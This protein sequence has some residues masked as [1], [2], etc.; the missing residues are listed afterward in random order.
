MPLDSKTNHAHKLIDHLVYMI[1]IK[2]AQGGHIDILTE[3]NSFK[4]REQ[5]SLCTLDTW[6]LG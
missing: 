3:H 2:I 4:R 1:Y 5:R 6:D